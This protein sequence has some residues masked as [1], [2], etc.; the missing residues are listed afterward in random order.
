MAKAPDPKAGGLRT[1]AE[2]V[3]IGYA[4]VGVEPADRKQM[5]VVTNHD[6]RVL[7]RRTV[8]CKAWDG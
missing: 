6:S 1:G 2:A 7:A 4:I 3:P 5:V 8:R